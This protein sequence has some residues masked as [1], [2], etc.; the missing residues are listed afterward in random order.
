MG[1]LASALVKMRTLDTDGNGYLDFKEFI[2][3]ND[4]I[5]ARTPEQKLS[6]AF[7]VYDLNNNSTIDK[8]E[9]VKVMCSIYSMVDGNVKDATRGATEEKASKH[10]E[11]LF[12]LIDIDGDGNLTEQE[13]LR[14]CL[15]DRE[16]LR[17]LDKI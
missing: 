2:M 4:L 9:M 17:R 6:W 3:A 8:N 7:K 16:L 14:G 10:A 11:K 13:F 1:V 12:K 5:A 15:Q